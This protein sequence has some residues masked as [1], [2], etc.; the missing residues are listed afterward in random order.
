MATTC[1]RFRA[2]HEQLKLRI[3]FTKTTYFSSSFSDSS[4]L[5][6]LSETLSHEFSQKGRT[7]TNMIKKFVNI[8][9]FRKNSWAKTASKL[10]FFSPY[11]TLN[12]VN[13]IRFLSQQVPSE[14]QTKAKHGQAQE[15]F[16]SP[17]GHSGSSNT[18]HQ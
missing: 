17:A 11:Y 16:H 6:D 8:R 12:F 5:S 7:P 13:Y 18:C 10:L 3:L 1:A 4:D 9:P 2:S 15:K 14:P